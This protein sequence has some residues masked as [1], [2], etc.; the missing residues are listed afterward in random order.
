MT[1]NQE[2]IIVGGGAVG[3]ACA[4]ELAVAGRSV[5]LVDAG[6]SDGAGWR[7]AAGM[8]APQIEARPDD[9]LFELG[10]AGRERYQQI[11]GALK[12]STG[13]DIGF[14]Q[15]GIARVAAD[16]AEVD[17]LKARVAWQRQQGHVCDWFDAEEVKTR[18]PWLGPTHGALWAPHEAALEPERLVEALLADAVR[19][20]AVI[21]EDRIHTLQHRGAKVT[22]VLGGEKHDAEH[23]IITA[24]SWS[25]QIAGLPR[26][27]PIVPVR[28]QMAAL[29]WPKGIERA[30]VFGKDC[31]LVARGEEAIAGSTMEHS[32]YDAS[33]TPAGLAHIFAS[34]CALCPAL[35]GLDVTRTWAGLRPMTPDGFPIL[36]REPRMEGL[37][38][39]T[40]HGRNGIL[41]AGITGVIMAQLLNGE[42]PDED[43]TACR[44]ERFFDW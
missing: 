40:G 25:P 20:G 13:I 34:V 15:E 1:A 35:A 11:A 44:P 12:E 4:R 18:W 8:L 23:V 36:G 37:W 16:E 26:P 29:P 31:Y 38:Y 3:A 9:P 19:A 5:R 14:W 21:R 41:L 28:G 10:L 39:A 42:Q 30:I 24:G 32:G 17:E 27:L 33:V 6:R 2:V 43:L 22:G 7:A